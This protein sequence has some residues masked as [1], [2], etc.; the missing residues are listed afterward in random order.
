MLKLACRGDA[1]RSWSRQLHQT[2]VISR[3]HACYR[4]ELGEDVLR[5]DKALREKRTSARKS[6]GSESVPRPGSTNRIEILGWRSAQIGRHGCG[7]VGGAADGMGNMHSGLLEQEE[8]A[9]KC[10]AFFG[11][12]YNLCKM[13][14]PA[15]PGTPAEHA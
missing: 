11:F 4:C 1:T 2:A 6:Q 14:G 15:G 8:S 13:L 12:W 9:G 10:A 5:S 7:A 3:V